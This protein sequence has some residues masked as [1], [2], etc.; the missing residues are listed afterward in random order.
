[1]TFT[2]ASQAAQQIQERLSAGDKD[3]ARRLI[4]QFAD[5]IKRAATNAAAGSMLEKDPDRL[6]DASLDAFFRTVVL[7]ATTQYGIDAPV[8]SDVQALR[9]PAFFLPD[10]FLDDSFRDLIRRETPAEFASRNLW[11]RDRDLRSV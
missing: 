10:E 6:S 3:F 8:W 9:D 11:I 4:T 2:T 1:M 5:T 7:W